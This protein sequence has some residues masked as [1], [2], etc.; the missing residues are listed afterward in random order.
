M[1]GIR[2]RPN[3][4]FRE[5]NMPKGSKLINIIT[6]EEAI[7]KTERTVE[8]R[9]GIVYLTDATKTILGRYQNPCTQ[10][11]HNGK[12]LSKLHEEIH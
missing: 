1:A 2:R 3:L 6:D 4:N 9:N 10:W 8:F 12:I 11:T 7:V 5:M